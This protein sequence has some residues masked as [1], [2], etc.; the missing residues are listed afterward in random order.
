MNLDLTE[1]IEALARELA[2]LEPGEDWPSNEA[3]GGS[4]TGTRDNEFRSGMREQAA[5]HLKVV[6]PLIA[7]AVLRKVATEPEILGVPNERTRLWLNNVA[8]A[9]ELGHVAVTADGRD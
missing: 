4:P 2:C 9:Y 8:T 7:A 1:A 6:A 5:D 3:L